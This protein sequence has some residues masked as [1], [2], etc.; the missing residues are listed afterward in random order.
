MDLTLFRLIQRLSGRINVADQFMI[1]ISNKIRYVYIFIILLFLLNKHFKKRITIETG[2]SVLLSFLLHMLIKLFYY[3]PRPFK[4]RRVGILIPSKMDSSFPSKHTILAF[5][6][7]VSILMFNRTLGI[8][9]L[10]LSAVTGFSRVWVGHHYPS[11]IIGS[12]I[13]GA[14]SSIIMRVIS[15]GKFKDEN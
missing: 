15:F 1:F 8:F 3:K 4:K 6:A 9:M 12:A 11:D 7:S 10:G 13:L 14:L 5:A 2:G